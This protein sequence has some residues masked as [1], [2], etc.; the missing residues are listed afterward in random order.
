MFERK[1]QQSTVQNGIKAVIKDV[2]IHDEDA[3]NNE[4][5]GIANAQSKRKSNPRKRGCETRHE[6]TN[7][8]R[9]SDPGKCNGD[10]KDRKQKTRET[11]NENDAPTKK[12]KSDVNEKPKQHKAQNIFAKKVPSKRKKRLNERVKKPLV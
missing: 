8:E 11:V 3:K 7:E 9:K 10:T 12:I 2:Q 5:N 6:M 4:D 1:Q